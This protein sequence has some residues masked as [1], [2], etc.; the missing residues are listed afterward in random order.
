MIVCCPAS[1]LLECDEPWTAL[2]VHPDQLSAVA[3]AIDELVMGGCPI[4]GVDRV[5]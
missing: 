2:A 1:A 5:D 3:N 4:A